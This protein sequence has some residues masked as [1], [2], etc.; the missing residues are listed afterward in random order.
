MKIAIA[1]L[2]AALIAG[3]ASAQAPAAPAS[4]DPA[5]TSFTGWVRITDGEFQLYEN[6]RQVELPFARP[7]V[8]GAL[9]RGAQ[10]SAHDLNGAQ[11]T[12]TGQAVPWASR[13]RAPVIRHQGSYI[14][15]DCGGPFVIEAQ[16][17]RVL[18]S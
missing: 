2:A 1:T 16:D 18:G 7:C 4:F 8:S 3:A 15:N 10:R 12:F 6:K 14:R 11:V 9:P 13:G 5:A 17:V